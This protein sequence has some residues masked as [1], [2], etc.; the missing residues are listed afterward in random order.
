MSS[1]MH[2]DTDERI[3][4][5]VQQGDVEAFGVLM[6]R[7]EQRLVRYATRFLLDQDIVSDAVQE[8]FI[9]AYRNIQSFDISRSFSPWIYRIA[10]NECMTAL[11]KRKRSVPILDFDTL[12]TIPAPEDMVEEADRA[13]MKEL[14]ETYLAKLPP[15]YREVLTLFYLEDMEY[16]T[17][18]EVL[19]IP[20]GTVGIRLRRA[21]RALARLMEPHVQ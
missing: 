15:A 12:I 19:R 14:V 8:T 4:E 10:H 7:Y 9:Q 20:L 11:R 1:D 21:R 5:K 6:R 2:E 16:K 18:A 13:R 3:A 17:I